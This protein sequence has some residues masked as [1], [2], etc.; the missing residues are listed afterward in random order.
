MP[1]PV[2]GCDVEIVVLR[3]AR[4]RQ[5]RVAHAAVAADRNG[6]RPRKPLLR[7]GPGHPAEAAPHLVGQSAVAPCT[8]A[9]SVPSSGWIGQR[10]GRCAANAIARLSISSAIHVAGIGV[11]VG[12]QPPEFGEQA[13]PPRRDPAQRDAGLDERERTQF[14]RGQLVEPI[15]GDA[16][17]RR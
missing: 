3:P 12:Q 9:A 15:V 4:W 17:L 14:A 2:F 13:R 5:V 10:A 6:V 1:G 7:C 8:P 11:E 16:F